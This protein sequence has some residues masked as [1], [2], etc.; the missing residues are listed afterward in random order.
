M[1]KMLIA[2]LIF[3]LLLV[4]CTM[5]GSNGSKDNS[6]TGGANADPSKIPQPPSGE[7]NPDE[8]PPNLPF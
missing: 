6:S 2:L 5:T 1:K 4:G 3:G 8:T 7:G